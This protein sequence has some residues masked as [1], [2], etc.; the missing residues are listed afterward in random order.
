MFSHAYKPEYL[1]SRSQ[2]Y[3]LWLGYLVTKK[4]LKPTADIIHCERSGTS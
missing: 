1:K 2:K 4:T 3:V